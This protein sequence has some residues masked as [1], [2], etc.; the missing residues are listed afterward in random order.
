MTGVLACLIAQT[1][2]RWHEEVGREKHGA[3]K[4]L[5]GADAGVCEGQE[6]VISTFLRLGFKK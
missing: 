3:N 1:R 5:F 2:I 6:L 4:Q